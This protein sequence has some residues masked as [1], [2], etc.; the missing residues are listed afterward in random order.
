M[1]GTEK[2]IK[3]KEKGKERKQNKTKRKENERNK[4]YLQIKAKQSISEGMYSNFHLRALA[5]QCSSK[6]SY[7]R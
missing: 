3:E 1:D 4:P 7:L 2:P 5:R 6:R